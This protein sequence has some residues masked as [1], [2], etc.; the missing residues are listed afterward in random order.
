MSAPPSGMA[1]PRAEL[2]GV[3]SCKQGAAR[4]KA[5]GF[6]LCGEAAQARPGGIR[7]SMR[8]LGI[9]E[10]DSLSGRQHVR[11]QQEDKRANEDAGPAGIGGGK[12]RG[13]GT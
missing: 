4:S 9:E 6:R 11:G 3:A 12:A 1:I 13:R 8:Q 10:R 7:Y 5:A 2:T